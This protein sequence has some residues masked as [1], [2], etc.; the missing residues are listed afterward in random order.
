MTSA[1]LQQFFRRARRVPGTADERIYSLTFAR[2]ALVPYAS[3]PLTTT[4]TNGYPH[5]GRILRCGRH[6]VSQPDRRY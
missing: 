6:P 1:P 4:A 3:Q 2:I 5:M